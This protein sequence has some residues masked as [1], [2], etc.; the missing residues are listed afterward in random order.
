M[1]TDWTGD[2][3]ETPAVH[4]KGETPA[5]C[6]IA[7]L[8][9]ALILCAVMAVG[10]APDVAAAPVGGGR[11]L[12]VST[13][14]S[15]SSSGS[16]E[17]PW[18]TPGYASKQ[19]QGG[20]TLTI[21][22]GRYRLATYWDDMITPPA[23]A[24]AATPIVIKGEQGNR[25][26]LAGADDLFS[27]ADISGCSYL[28]LENLEITSDG[29][30]RF[31]GGVAGSGA[32][33][34]HVLL[35]D[36]YI[37]HI[38]EGAMDFAD[39]TDLTVKDCV[40]SYCGFGG[41]GGPAGQYGGWRNV[42][43]DGCTLSYSG[44][45]YQ[46]G[47]GPSPYDRP[48]GFGIEASE[49]PIE[50]KNTLA[51]H[52]RGDG[53]DCKAANTYIH[54]CVVAN[55]SCDGVKLWGHDSRLLNALVYGTGDGQGGGSPWA[56][57]VASE[58]DTPNAQFTIE[59][60]TVGDNPA[61]DAYPIYVQY[62]SQVPMSLTVRNTVIANG[63]GAPYFGPAVKL[64]CENNDFFRPGEPDN[65]VEAN[66]RTYSA[67]ELEGGALGPGNISKDPAFV[68]PAWGSQGDYHLKAGSPAI[69]SGTAVGA[70]A[71]DLDGGGR[72]AGA[73][74]DMGCYEYGSNKAT[75]TRTWGH[76]SVG[77]TMPAK[78]WYCAEGSTA[79]DFETWVL[80]QNP[81]SSTATAKV[82]YMLASGPREGPTVNLPPRSRATVN[83]EDTVGEVWDVAASV[84]SDRPVIVERASYWGD[85]SAA[86]ESIGASTAS[87]DW[88]LAEG[89]TGG[90][91]ETWVLVQNP[92]TAEAHVAI[93]Y[94]TGAG[95]VPGP[96]FTLGAGARK[97]LNVADTVPSTWS[98]STS[99]SSDVPVV[100]E[101]AVYWEGRRG[102]HSSVGVTAGQTTW[103]LA[104]GSTGGDF[105]TWILI[106]N[107]GAA[108]ARAHLSY[109]TG[110]GRV[111]GPD[112]TVP[113]R[114]RTT[115]NAA[116]VVPGTWSV[117]TMV[118]ADTPV[119]A[120]RAVY[121][122]GRREGHG[123]TGSA[124][125]ATEWYLAEGSTGPGFQT[126]V[127]V[128]NPGATTATVTFSFMTSGGLEPGPVIL[129]AAGSRLS[130]NVGDH[131]PGRWSIS[132]CL[133]SSEGVVAERAMYGVHSA[134]D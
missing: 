93:T 46:G 80:I 86:H 23:G 24:T 101:R 124:A 17:A 50:I 31:R 25:P 68:A 39:V 127:L 7:N 102:G 73:G 34:D 97:S 99:V 69:D 104:E 113:P 35:K 110:S 52:N 63:S 29:G 66:G 132:T 114:G 122:G 4:R 57:I 47:P 126:W 12:Y 116:D 62:D 54:E 119:V 20:D 15:D 61:R 92:G 84:T 42:V 59:N 16:R 89:S 90:G 131:L 6:R 103:F 98:V 58:D 121:W 105:E 74:F 118:S 36:L 76:D 65:Q 81:G 22:G 3:G 91:F 87:P 13:G 109:Q 53:L 117:A 96:G 70:P 112:V 77:A 129:L 10:M 85:R 94:S 78:E 82:T 107:P 83:A 134:G 11:S 38:D 71:I 60:V 9:F 21:L 49:G 51:E 111:E 64:T 88:Y 41:M 44:H 28:T 48:D 8:L 18:R 108:Q 115:V 40:M 130:L 128:Q 95:G 125:T 5:V 2:A 72:P 120:E 1:R 30:S 43:V 56:G 100:A 37:H 55:N 133:L 26:V 14:G 32:P 106:M 45:Y 27:A 33:I 123:S 79:G 67:A 75:G 19:L